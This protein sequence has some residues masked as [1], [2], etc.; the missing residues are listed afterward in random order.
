MNCVNYKY[1]PVVNS[2]IKVN[3]TEPV[4]YYPWNEVL[5]VKGI[6]EK[7]YDWF[8][9]K[10]GDHYCTKTPKNI[11]DEAKKWIED[12]SN[13]NLAHERALFL[14]GKLNKAQFTKLV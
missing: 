7:K 12:N 3:V 9:K 8:L 1:Q 6:P 4:I 14:K 10:Y 13:E 2:I 5:F 11:L